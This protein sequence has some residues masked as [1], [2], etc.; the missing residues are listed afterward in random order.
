MGTYTQ[1]IMSEQ[2]KVTATEQ[3][4]EAQPEATPETAK[5]DVNYE[6][7]E[8]KAQ[9]ETVLVETKT[10]EESM[11]CL[12]KIRCKL[13]RNRE[14]MDGKPEWKER[15]IGF[16]KLQRDRATRKIRFLLRQEKTLKPMANFLLEKD[17]L[18]VLVPM[19]NQTAGEEKSWC[20]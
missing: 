18:C 14:G 6:T 9:V 7:E 13:Y 8:T 4:A 19:A 10:G 11:E 1:I 12:M 17:P 3:T 5:H 16:M 15:G 2:E 20:W